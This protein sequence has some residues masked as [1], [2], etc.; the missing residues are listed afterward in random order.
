MEDVYFYGT[1]KDE[2]FHRSIAQSGEESKF[3][4]AA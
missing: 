2:P 4:V 1:V 3:M